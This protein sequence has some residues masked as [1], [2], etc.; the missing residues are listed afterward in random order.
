M[1]ALGGELVAVREPIDRTLGIGVIAILT[2]VFLGAG[3]VASMRASAQA[4]GLMAVQAAFGGGAFRGFGQRL[5]RPGQAPPVVVSGGPAP[6]HRPLG[7]ERV[8]FHH[9]FFGLGL[10]VVGVGL[11][12]G[13]YGAPIADV[14]MSAPVLL[15]AV[16]PIPDGGDR[17]LVTHEECRSETRTVPSEAGG[18]RQIK[19]T[20]CRKG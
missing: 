6:L 20:W 18:E 11:P 16:A 10:P 14:G 7:F 17:I 4:G 15:H 3:L 5:V 13:P 8:R 9:R 2:V 19:I 1:R 12:F